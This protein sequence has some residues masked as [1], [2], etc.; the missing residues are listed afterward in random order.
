MLFK[1][2]QS[3]SCSPNPL[4]ERKNES[5]NKRVELL[6]PLLCHGLSSQKKSAPVE[7]SADGDDFNRSPQRN[8]AKRIQTSTSLV[9]CTLGKGI[10]G[11]FT[12]RS[13][14]R[15][16]CIS[17]KSSFFCRRSRCFAFSKSNLLCS[18]MDRSSFLTTCLKYL[19]L[20]REGI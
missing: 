9:I 19:R 15:T 5:T 7:E 14:S 18:R 13:S 10:Q 20:I 3:K 8:K 11:L 12:L 6:K 17:S 4:I 1:C 16:L 2:S